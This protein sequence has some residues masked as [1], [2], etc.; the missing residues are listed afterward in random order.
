MFTYHI[1]LKYLNTQKK[2]NTRHAKWVSFLQGYNFVLKHKSRKQNQVADALSRRVVLL[3]IMEIEMVG[4]DAI[5]DLY[6]S[7]S[8]FWEVID[9]LKNPILGHAYTIQGDY[10]MQDGYLFKGKQL[11]V[12]IGS[13][14]ENII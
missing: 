6:E 2:L 14:R 8:D 11:C 1:V 7:D 4:F 13:M 12:P 3:N 9:R 10:L 5:K